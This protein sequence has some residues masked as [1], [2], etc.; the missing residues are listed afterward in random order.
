MSFWKNRPKH[1]AE[2]FALL[3]V[4]GPVRLLPYRA[5]LALAWVLAFVAFHLV[6]WRRAQAVARIREV[7]GGQFTSHQIRRIAWISMRN[8]FF[9]AAEAMRLNGI[10]R[11]WVERHTDTADVEKIRPVVK[12]GG[13]IL[14]VPHTGSWDLAGVAGHLFELPMFIIVGRQKNPLADAFVNKMRGTTGI[15]T[16]PRDSTALRGTIRRLKDG[17][18]LT[19]MT[20]LR[21]K[22]P[23]VKAQFLG[24]EANLVAGMGMFARMADVPII[25]AVVT[26][27][28]WTHHVWRVFDPVYPDA[29]LERD[30]DVQRMT[31]HVMNIFDAAIRA[32]PEQYFW[33]NK[34]WV[35]DP[36]DTSKPA[37]PKPPDENR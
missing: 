25:P 14:V 12:G 7:F 15:E 17:K 19:F 23:G 28:G 1:I 16:I 4:A 21:S 22:T 37:P 29:S 27:R 24:K 34:R 6:R 30:A 9:N 5:A 8:L 31:Q 36:I 11:E 26:R 18:M 35:L 32:E 10:T 3:A 20:D 13:S 2:Y 33:Y